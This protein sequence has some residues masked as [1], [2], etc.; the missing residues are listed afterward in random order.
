M[1][2][3]LLI[4]KK[5]PNLITVS[6]V[7]KPNSINAPDDRISKKEALARINNWNTYYKSWIQQQIDTNGGIYQVF[8]IPFVDIIPN[9][10]HT[11]RFCAK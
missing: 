7:I 10:S 1:L 6:K 4:S 9:N 2:S 11:A 5:N 8:V 3:T